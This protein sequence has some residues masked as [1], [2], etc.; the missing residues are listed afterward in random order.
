MISKKSLTFLIFVF[1]ILVNIFSWIVTYDLNKPRDFEVVFFDVGQGDSALIKTHLGHYILI[2]GGETSIIVEKL[3]KE[4]PFWRKEID[5]IILTHAH[6]DHLG[7]LIDVMENYHVENVLWNGVEAE[8]ALFSKWER[9]LKDGDYDIKISQS[10]QKIKSK[11][12]VLNVLYPF[13][14]IENETFNDLNLSS[15]VLRASYSDNSFLF[16]GDAYESMEMDLIKMEDFCKDKKQEIKCRGMVLN[17]DVL[18]VGHHGSRTSTS[19]DFL[20]R[21][22]PLIAVISAGK[23]NRFNHPHIETL[24]V[25]E[26]YDIEILRTDIDGDIKITVN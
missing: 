10:G 23:D 3:S 7:G 1:L 16:M 25:L 26:K 8:T 5:L 22:K 11:D 20:K 18:K 15:I 4:I 12:F 6:A 9:M 24:E 14:K 2:D 13:E 19:D 17:S 21:V